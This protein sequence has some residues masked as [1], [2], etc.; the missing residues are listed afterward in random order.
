MVQTVI[1]MPVELQELIRETYE[2]T[3]WRNPA[4]RNKPFDEHSSVNIL[5]YWEKTPQGHAFWSLVN[6]GEY[7]QAKLYACYPFPK[8]TIIDN[9]Q[10]F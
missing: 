8:D 6:T 2:V 4:L 5:L 10:I 7:S 9:Y 3:H 1:N